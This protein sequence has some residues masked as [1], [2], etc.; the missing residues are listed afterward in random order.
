MPMVRLNES[1]TCNDTADYLKSSVRVTFL[2]LCSKPASEAT[3][4]VFG[5]EWTGKE[6]PPTAKGGRSSILK[7]KGAMLS[8]LRWFAG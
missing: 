2:M 5:M 7:E 1:K 3:L 6:E 8:R 4:Q